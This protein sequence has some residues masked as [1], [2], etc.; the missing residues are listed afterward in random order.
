MK[1][2]PHL[3]PSVVLVPIAGLGAIARIARSRA[4]MPTTVLADAKLASTQQKLVSAM[5][6]V[7]TVCFF[8]ARLQ[9]IAR[10]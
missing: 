10:V 3:N 6:F 4:A 9:H 1:T 8:H 7:G 2:W 5:L